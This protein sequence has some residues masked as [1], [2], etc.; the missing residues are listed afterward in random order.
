VIDEEVGKDSE[1]ASG[2]VPFNASQCFETG[3]A[4]DK[5]N[6]G[7]KEICGVGESISAFCGFLT[8]IASRPHQDMA[9]VGELGG[10]HVRSNGHRGGFVICTPVL[11]SAQQDISGGEAV[12]RSDEFPVGI[13]KRQRDMRLG[14]CCHECSGA[15]N[16]PTEAG[17][18]IQIMERNTQLGY[19]FM[20]NLDGGTVFPQ[21]STFQ[22]DEESI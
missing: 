21:I 4:S 7:S 5:K 8:V 9:C 6:S 3:S 22:C 17:D 15:G 14:T 20:A 12:G 1:V 13:V 19:A 2:G 16:I 18:P 10:D 11:F